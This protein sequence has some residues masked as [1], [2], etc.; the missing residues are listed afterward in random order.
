MVYL[1]SV[2]RN[3]FKANKSSQSNL[4][5]VHPYTLPHRR[6]RMYS[7]AECASCTM[8]NVTEPL[9]KRYGTLWNVTDHYS[10][11][12]TASGTYQPFCHSI[13]SGPTDRPKDGL[14]EKPVPRVL[15][16]TERRSKNKQR[17]RG[18]LTYNCIQQPSGKC[19]QS[20]INDNCT[21]LPFGYVSNTSVSRSRGLRTVL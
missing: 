14:G 21:M 5:R 15:T 8:C 3:C 11:P 17:L 6:R 10:P 16:L 4:G 7:P 13:L 12:Q 9:R 1:C 18:M 20:Y 2:Q 19:S